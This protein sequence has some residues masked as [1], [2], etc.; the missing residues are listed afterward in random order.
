MNGAYENQT[1]QTGTNRTNTS[2]LSLGGDGA[3]TNYLACR[4]SNFQIYNRALSTAEIQQN[5]E[6]IKTRF[7]L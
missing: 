7:G 6:A 2:S 1:A 5:Y 4:I 3:S